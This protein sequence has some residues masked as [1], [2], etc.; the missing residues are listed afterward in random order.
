VIAKSA[1]GGNELLKPQTSNTE[2]EDR[3]EEANM[4]ICGSTRSARNPV[5]VW[6]KIVATFVVE[7][8]RVDDEGERA[9][10]EA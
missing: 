1:R 7:R 8:R 5:P 3:K 6:P 2:S 9:R 10:D 4:R